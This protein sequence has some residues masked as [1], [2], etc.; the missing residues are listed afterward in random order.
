MSHNHASAR[1]R[2]EHRSHPR[3]TGQPT[4]DS[5]WFST[6]GRRCG[7]VLAIAGV[8]IS[9]V[10]APAS[11]GPVSASAV[12]SA[13]SASAVSASTTYR[14]PALQPFSVTSPAN[15][16]F[17][18]GAKFESSSATKTKALLR[19]NPMLNAASWSIAVA[20]AT[21]KDP[22]AK[23]TNVS[24]GEVLH[25]RMPS[26]AQVTTG[27]DKHMTVVQPDGHTAYECY[28]M[29]KVGTNTWTTTYLVE[30]DLRT[31][32]LD[33]GARASGISQV[34]GLIRSQEVAALSIPH[35]LAIGI[36]DSM[37]KSGQVWPARLQDSNASS[38]YKGSIP[39]G[40]ML[41]IPPSVDLTKLGLTAEGMALGKAMQ[42]YGAHVLVRSDRVALFAEPVSDAAKVSRMRADYVHKLF[43]LLRVVTNN[44]ESNVAGGGTRR[45]P[46]AAPLAG[47]AAPAAAPGT[48]TA[49]SQAKVTAVTPGDRSAT[50]AWS[51]PSS[52]G[53]SAITGY[54]V[55]ASPG[56]ASATTAGSGRT[57]VVR[58]LIAGRQY[59][60][61][62]T[63][64]NA[65]RTGAA[66]AAS[67]R[68]QLGFSDVPSSSTFASHIAWFAAKGIGPA[69]TDGRFGPAVHVNRATLATYLYRLAGSPSR[70]SG[71]ALF[72]D[73]PSSSAAF[74]DIQWLGAHGYSTGTR[75]AN[76]T[77][78]FKP[79][80]EVSKGAMAVFLYRF[81]GSPRFT[82]PARSPFLDVPTT[83]RFYKEIA[84]L[85]A[86]GITNGTGVPG[87]R[88]FGPRALMTREVT[89]MFLHRFDVLT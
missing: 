64:K 33:G 62:V 57:A 1:H 20:I 70:S 59:T 51:A 79:S 80:D 76:G 3:S 6:T 50:V 84:W 49:P 40:T 45:R 32:G 35:T 87:G 43:P 81:A 7:V 25:F 56:G 39:M 38:A 8:V 86:T 88:A 66:S 82:A 52:T 53:G 23:V 75:L 48:V 14:N 30:T 85:A 36:P 18:S 72:A 37:L 60:F 22:L 4:S 9:G 78:L 5:R 27:T 2:S 71:A 69:S 29:T 44:S 15:V 42:D 47:S 13:V 74:A 26:G 55:V 19:G 61:T 58:G 73:V 31:D 24:N 17:G 16:S 68:V 34:M 89:A 11:A 54:T 12:S 46:P 83:D 41:G 28:K 10:T 77:R 67:A 63:A 65:S 21:S